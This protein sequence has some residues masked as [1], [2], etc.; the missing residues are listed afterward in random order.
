MRIPFVS[1]TPLFIEE[2]EQIADG[3]AAQMVI[4]PVVTDLASIRATCPRPGEL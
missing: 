3:S 4:R 2:A 1:Q